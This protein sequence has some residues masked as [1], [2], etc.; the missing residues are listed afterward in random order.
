MTNKTPLDEFTKVVSRSFDAAVDVAD[1]AA[2][3]AKRF[4]SSDQ[5]RKLR[6]GVAG[7][8]IFGAPVISRLPVFRRTPM[9]RLFRTAAVAGLLVE[10]AEWLRD[11]EPDS[12]SV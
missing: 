2:A 7:A 10:A 8:V 12:R 4:L 6:R 3:V 9:G 5:G 11:W 1:D